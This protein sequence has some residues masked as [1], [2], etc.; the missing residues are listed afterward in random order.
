MPISLRL[1]RRVERSP[2]YGRARWWS[3]FRPFRVHFRRLFHPP[4]HPA[5]RQVVT[6]KIWPLY[7]AARPRAYAPIPRPSTAGISHHPIPPDPIAPVRSPGAIAPN[8][9][10]AD[11]YGALFELTPSA[12]PC[13]W[14]M[15][16]ITIFAIREKFV[17]RPI[18]HM[19]RVRHPTLKPIQTR[20]SRPIS[21]KYPHGVGVECVLNFGRFLAIRTQDVYYAAWWIKFVFV[22]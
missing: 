22:G 10:I 19:G 4:N 18:N 2:W 1:R 12:S 8:P 15:R 7:P 21:M 20:N 13:D 16:V 6:A 5:V 11:F 17:I 14:D 9:L 3:A